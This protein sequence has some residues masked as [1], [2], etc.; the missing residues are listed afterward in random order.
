MPIIAL[1][2]ALALL[3]YA[4]IAAPRLRLAVL[5]FGL[6]V[7]LGLGVYLVRSTPESA[8]EIIRIA[9]ED[10]T[11]DQTDFSR[12]GRGAVLT[13]R[14]LNGSPDWHLRDMT[15]VLHIRDCPPETEDIAACPI[16][17]EATALTHPDTPPG[18][19]RAFRALFALPNLPP[20]TGELRWDW[21]VIATRATG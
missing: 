11:L 3:A 15:L 10:L 7:A 14:V 12:Q 5:A 18:Q 9:P 2:A 4:T 16:I 17:G 19:I 8:R 1:V 21:R 20:A 13:G 6:A